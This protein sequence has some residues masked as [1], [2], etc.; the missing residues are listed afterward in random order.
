[1]SESAFA[2]LVAR[3]RTGDQQAAMDL[4]RLYEPVIRRAIRFRLSNAGLRS[5]LDSMDICQS[6]LSSFF[7]RAASGQYQLDQPEDLQKLLTAM[8]RNKLKMQVRKQH[9]QRRDQRRLAA[10][11]DPNVVAAPGPTASQQLVAREL[12]Q[13]A[14]A[15]LSPEERALVEWR[16]QGLE[17]AAIAQRLDGNPEA[18]RKRLVRAL[19]RVAVEL[20]IEEPG[21]D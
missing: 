2:D 17:W 15:R 6:V 3:I 8:A 5:T 7:M 12:L 9:S 21:H 13:E 11:A 4:V 1:M 14:H 20:G 18:L 10:G 16:Q 19:D